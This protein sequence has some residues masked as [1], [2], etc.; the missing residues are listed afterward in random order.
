M[1]EKK[2]KD[3]ETVINERSDERDRLVE[4]L[5]ETKRSVELKENKIVELELEITNLKKMSHRA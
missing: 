2:I 1:F 3:M 4:E 5:D